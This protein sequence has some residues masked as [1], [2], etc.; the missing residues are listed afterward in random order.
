MNPSPLRSPTKSRDVSV[1]LRPLLATDRAPL[2]AILR[3]T[4]VFGDHEIVVALEL[5]D[6]KPELDYRFFVAEVEGQVAGY[7]CY[8]AT[9][10][11]EG[12]WDLYWIAVDPTLHRSGV[13]RTLMKATED[14]IRAAGG[15][16][17]IIETGSKPALENTRAFY[18]EYGCAE[19]ARVPDFYSVGDD[20]VVYARRLR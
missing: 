6:A 3:A 18:R 1:A 4:R 19:V 10:C 15:R 17:M 20:K 9:P 5:I 7:S 11:T 14:A 12:T 8:G 2:E 16:Q 13:G